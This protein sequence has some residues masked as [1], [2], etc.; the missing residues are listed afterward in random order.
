MQ[1]E[2]KFWAALNKILYPK[3][4]VQTSQWYLRKLTNLSGYFSTKITNHFR[5]NKF[6]TVWIYEDNIAQ[7]ERVVIITKN[8][9]L[10]LDDDLLVRSKP[11]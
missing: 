3:Y 10:K 5:Q 8:F 1:R 6:M 4:I 7:L 2:Y 9:G 11:S